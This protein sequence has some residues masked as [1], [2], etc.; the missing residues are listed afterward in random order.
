VD[1]TRKTVSRSTWS[2]GP[3]FHVDYMKWYFAHVPRANGVNP[4]GK[5][6]NWYKYIY[7]FNSYDP[8]GQPLA[9]KVSLNYPNIADPKTKTHILQV[10]YRCPEQ[11]DPVSLDDDD[12]SVTD[13]NGKMLTV[14]LLAG[15]EPGERSY[16]VGFYEVSAPVGTWDAAPDAT[17]TVALRP[18][19]VRTRAGTALAGAKLGNFRLATP[20]TAML[21]VSVPAEPVAI[22]FPAVA[23]A[24]IQPKD[25]PF[26]LTLRVA[27]SSSDKK[28]ATVD[29]LGVV[30]GV[31]PGQATI[32]ARTGSQSASASVKVVAPDAP[33]ARLAAVPDVNGAVKDVTFDV[34]YES[35][36]GIRTKSLGVG[37]LRVVG[38][39]GFHRFPVVA[40]VKPGAS[41][42][43]T[44]TY[45]VTTPAGRWRAGLYKIEMLAFEVT[46]MDGKHVTPG[47][48]G[49]FRVR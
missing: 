5:Q 43:V 35:A 16:R 34:V 26:D 46:D 49:E 45:R 47:G 30:R 36:K 42:A 11:V 12:I 23:R 21:K 1:F 44:V 8:K 10:E 39:A 41:G 27:W 3:D 2:K 40:S 4:D 22:G 14:K 20:G 24:S 38:P 25:K 9:A 15:N 28:V 31:M 6:N 13:A 19:Q 17:Y 18:N 7:D 48:L 37:D 29:A 33:K 32:T